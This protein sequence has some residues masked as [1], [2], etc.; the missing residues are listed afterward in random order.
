MSSKSRK[1]LYR[2]FNQYF[3]KQITELTCLVS[4][5]SLELA[6][7]MHEQYRATQ[8]HHFKRIIKPHIL[9]IIP[10]KVNVLIL[11]GKN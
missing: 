3:H 5:E 4:S 11:M 7:L 9:N 6:K 2:I 10:K 8:A 1:K